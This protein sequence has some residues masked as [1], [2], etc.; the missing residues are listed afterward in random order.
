MPTALAIV[1]ALLGLLVTGI[2]VW[3]AWLLH[4]APVK[5]EAQQAKGESAD[6]PLPKQ[7]HMFLQ[8]T[9]F[10]YAV[11]TLFLLGTLLLGMNLLQALQDAASFPPYHIPYLL[12]GVIFSF[13]GMLMIVLR[14]AM[15]MSLARGNRPAPV[16]DEHHQPAHTEHAE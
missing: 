13:L 3:T 16:P 7:A 9:V 1:G 8:W 14:L 11:L 12:C 5:P 10:D 2:A 6:S 4:K 15:T